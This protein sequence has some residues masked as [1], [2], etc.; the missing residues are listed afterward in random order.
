MADSALEQI[1]GAQDSKTRRSLWPANLGLFSGGLALCA[2]YYLGCVLGFMLFIPS[3]HFSMF[4]LPNTLLVAAL[5]LSRRRQW[6][7]FLLIPF[8]VHVLAHRQFGVSLGDATFYY[9]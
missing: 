6:P 8:P 7:G 2:T 4:W 9:A 3:A 1:R 5:L